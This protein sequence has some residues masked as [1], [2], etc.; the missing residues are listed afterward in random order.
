MWCVRSADLFNAPDAK[1]VGQVVAVVGAKG[2]VG[3]SSIAHNI[4][5]A[6]ARDWRS[7]R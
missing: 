2:G 7:T 4:A 5:W 3:A 6:A 1:P